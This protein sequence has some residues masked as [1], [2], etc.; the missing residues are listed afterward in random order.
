MNYPLTGQ[1][2]AMTPLQTVLPLSSIFFPGPGLPFACSVL[3]P[4]RMNVRYP[5]NNP[6]S[7]FSRRKVKGGWGKRGKADTLQSC[8]LHRDQ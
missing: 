2:K 7:R 6:L 4:V 8:K 1:K 3:H 5:Q